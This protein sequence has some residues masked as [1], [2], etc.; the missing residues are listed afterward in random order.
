MKRS[1]IRGS[2]HTHPRIPL[3]SM[4][5]TKITPPPPSPP[6]A[7]A[8]ASTRDPHVLPEAV[9]EFHQPPDRELA[10]R[11]RS[12]RSPDGAKRN[13]GFFALASPHSAAL[14]AGYTSPHHLHL[15]HPL[16]CR[17]LPAIRT[18][19]PRR[20][21]NSISKRSPDGAKRNPGL[22]AHASPHFAS[23]HPGYGLVVTGLVPVTPIR[24]ALRP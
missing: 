13:P 4:R 9:E 3:R 22:F 1:A 12:K 15:P 18:S 21:R 11:V 23:L 19:C 10:A 5:A 16:P 8:S 14:H 2:S 20:L 17:L 24:K 6:L 7:S